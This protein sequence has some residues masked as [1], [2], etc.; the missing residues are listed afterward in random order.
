MVPD[1]IL[2]Y[3][4]QYISEPS[5]ISD[6]V[7]VSQKKKKPDPGVEITPIDAYNISLLNR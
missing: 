2:S 1:D 4:E 6:T 7:I 5:Q 3:F